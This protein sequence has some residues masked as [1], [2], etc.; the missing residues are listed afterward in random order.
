MKFYCCGLVY[1]TRDPETYWCIETYFLRRPVD[2]IIGGK[3]IARQVVYTLCCKKH[4]CLKLEIHS[5]EKDKKTGAL[6]LVM[7]QAIKSEGARTFLERTKHMRIRQ[8]QCCP[9]R[10][11]TGSR[12]IP[13][14]YGKAVGKETQ[15]ARYIDESG[16]RQVFK[17]QKWQTEVHKSVLNTAFTD[18][19]EEK[20]YDFRHF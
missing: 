14:V 10:T 20:I 16:S 1:S 11:V 9:L 3:R 2:D 17:G 7:T 19:K 5:Y 8:P 15:A 13:W 12:K 4:G 6:K 18:K